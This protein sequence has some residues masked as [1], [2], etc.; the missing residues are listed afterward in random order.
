[1]SVAIT[2]R[3]HTLRIL[4][5][6]YSNAEAKTPVT[7]QTRFIVYSITKSFVALALLRQHDAG[8]LDLQAP[9]QRYL[10]WFST[11]AGGKP[12]LIH[13]LL[14]HTS[15][16]PTGYGPGGG[17]F[18][19]AELRHAHVLFAPGTSWSYANAGYDTLADVLAAVTYVPWQ[20]AV[21]TGVIE[22]IGM[23]QTVPYLTPTASGDVAYGYTFRDYDKAM[24]PVN[25]PLLINTFNGTYIDPAGSVVSSPEDMAKYMRFYLNAG[26]TESGQQLLTPAT[27]ARMTSADRYDD[28]KPAGAIHDELPEW[29]KFTAS[30]ASVLACNLQ[31]RIG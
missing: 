3:T 12:I 19:V 9:V 18:E 20:D 29:P 15:G 30:T 26:K 31:Q 5:F 16:L 6:G 21:I 13:Q 7:P 23:S 22:P 25:A 8:R 4:T 27:F 1:M 24:P 17:T 28:G 11:N 10:P 2:D 14:S